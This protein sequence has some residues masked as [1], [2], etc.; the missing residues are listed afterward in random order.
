MQ[1]IYTFLKRLGN[2]VLS[3]QIRSYPLV[4]SHRT[5]E[6]TLVAFLWYCEIVKNYEDK[7][8]VQ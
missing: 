2:L 6:Y 7:Y 1:A 5:T 4:L 3:R 8:V